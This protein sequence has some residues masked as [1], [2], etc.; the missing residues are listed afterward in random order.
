MET[1]SV[2][3]S[4]KLQLYSSVVYWSCQLHHICQWN[5]EKHE[6]DTEEAGCVSRKEFTKDHWVPW[7]DK[8]TN[9]EVLKWTGQQRLQDIVYVRDTGLQD[10]SPVWHQNT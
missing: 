6:Q 2:V 10:T 3:L 8:L 9:V 4:T 7:K 1:D 5:V